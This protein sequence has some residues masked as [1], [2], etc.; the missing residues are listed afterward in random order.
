[1]SVLVTGGAGYVGS[2][3]VKEL[4]RRGCHVIV[5]DN[6]SRGHREAARYG[7]L[8]EGDLADER[9]LAELFSRHRI[10]VV[11]HFAALAYVGE[12][13]AEPRRYYDGNVGNTLKLLGAM[14]DHGVSRFILSSTC[15]VYGDPERLPLTEDHPLRP[16]NPY[17]LSKFMIER[18]L[19]DYDRAYGLRYVSLRYFNAA[20][21]DPE[22]ELGERHEPET[23]LIPRLLLAA[24]GRLDRV[25]IFGSDYPTRDGTCVRDY[26]HVSDL[27]TAHTRAVEWLLDGGPSETFNVGT[28]RGHTVMEVVESCRRVAQ[29]PIEVPVGPRRPGDPAVLVCSNERARERL[30]WEPRFTEL[31]EIVATAWKWH[32]RAG[33]VS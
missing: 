26:V 32:R 29:R 22:G 27:A 14:L 21:A 1:M 7:E 5:F 19:A 11:L 18:V 25:E 33:L 16:I 31:E 28:G 13:V 8:V 17:G 10:E 2:H 15:A 12:S 24:L 6:L 30:G 9:A 3:T 23:H 20:G 4:S